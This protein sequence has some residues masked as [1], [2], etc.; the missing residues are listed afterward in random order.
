MGWA[1][2]TSHQSLLPQKSFSRLWRIESFVPQLAVLRSGYVNC[3]IS[4][5]GANSTLESMAHG[6]PMI[7]MP[8]FA[9]QYEWAGS[10]CDFKRAGIRIDKNTSDVEEIRDAVA[11]VL[12]DKSYRRNAEIAGGEM[13]EQA[14]VALAH[15][16]ARADERS[17]AGLPIAAAVIEAVLQG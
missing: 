17:G 1:L 7:C 4:H 10:V 15:L 9:D 12:E 11:E 8:F 14:E 3:F 16:G 2:P 5:C 13:R 6:V